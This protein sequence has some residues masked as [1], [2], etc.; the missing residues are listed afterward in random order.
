MKTFSSSLKK[1]Q[2]PVLP[3]FVKIIDSC[4]LLKTPQKIH[5][6][7]LSNF[8]R[9]VLTPAAQATKNFVLKLLHPVRKWKLNFCLSEEYDLTHCYSSISHIPCQRQ[10]YAFMMP[11]V[12]VCVCVCDASLVNTISWAR[13]DG[14]FSY[15]ACRHVILTGRNLLFLVKVVGVTVVKDWKP[16]NYDISSLEAW[17]FLHCT[18]EKPFH[19]F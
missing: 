6:N 7:F 15:L 12:Y 3:N 14:Y 17:I 5:D 10:I 8:Q 1:F 19:S 16:C 11:C 2:I 9:K 4:I 18:V 13:S